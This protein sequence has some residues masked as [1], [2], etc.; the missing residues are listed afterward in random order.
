MKRLKKVV[1]IAAIA[2]VIYVLFGTYR[3]GSQQWK[4]TDGHPILGDVGVLDYNLY[5]F[6]SGNIYANGQPIAKLVDYKF[7]L[8]DDI[9]V[10][11]SLDNKKARSRYCSK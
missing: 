9:I 3:I 1:L 7:R 8:V 4:Y 10:L 6:L 2:Y 5:G 11:E